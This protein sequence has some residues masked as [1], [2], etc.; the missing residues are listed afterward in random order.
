MNILIA[1]DHELFG[2]LIKNVVEAQQIAASVHTCR[3]FDD[4]YAVVGTRKI[5]QARQFDLVILDMRMPGMNGLS[6]LRRMLEV[7]QGAPVAIISGELTPSEAREAMREGAAGFLPKTMPLAEL[8]DA[9]RV[10]LMGQRYL[11]KFLMTDPRS[12]AILTRA[13]KVA[14]LGEL[15]TREQQV[16]NEVMQGWSNKQIAENLGITEITVKSHLMHLFPKLGAKNRTDAVRIALR[17][18]AD[19]ATGAEVKSEDADTAVL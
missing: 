6:G 10:L 4:A 7:A 11:P 1:D 18:K 8:A 19:A 9:L 2:E 12:E 3:N 17:L 14:T 16:L 5:G 13:A 15:T